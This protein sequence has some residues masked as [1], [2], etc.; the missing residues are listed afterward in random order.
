MTE[1][2]P[3][4]NNSYKCAACIGIFSG[5]K[6]EFYEYNG[7][8][9]YEA[10]CELCKIKK[11]D[12]EKEEKAKFDEEYAFYN[13]RIIIKTDDDFIRKYCYENNYDIMFEKFKYAGGSSY[14]PKA[15]PCATDAQNIIEEIQ[16]RFIL[17]ISDGKFKENPEKMIEIA[18]RI[19]NQL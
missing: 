12:N 17:D 3:F 1:N 4:D 7:E 16:R 15:N 10:Y 5:N 2:N 6:L 11:I 18:K 9:D 19:K 8:D 13:E 14:H